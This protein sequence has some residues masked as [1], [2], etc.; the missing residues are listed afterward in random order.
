[1]TGGV[2]EPGP[3]P[4]GLLVSDS[5]RDLI[6]AVLDQHVAEGRLTLDELELRVSLLLKP[7]TRIQAAAVLAGLPALEAPERMSRFH[8]GHH[9]EGSTPTLPSWLTPDGVVK[10]RTEEGKRPGDRAADGRSALERQQ[11]ATERYARALAEDN[12]LEKA[13]ADVARGEYE[14]VRKAGIV[15][16]SVAWVCPLCG[17]ENHAGGKRCTQCRREYGD[18]P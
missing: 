18:P 14:R 16:T 6:S 8:F 5:D 3:A 12:A 2:D 7:R 17:R 15:D 13:K 9:H 4:G 10:T 1:M 11:L